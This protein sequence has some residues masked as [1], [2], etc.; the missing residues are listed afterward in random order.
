MKD[1]TTSVIDLVDQAGAIDNQPV[2]D[3]LWAM[4]GRLRDRIEPTLGLVADPSAADLADLRGVDGS[5]VGRIEALTGPLT[6][7]AIHSWIGQP[8]TGFS[9]IHLTV[10]NP[11]TIRTPH[12]GVATGT[13]PLPWLLLDLPM[14]TD[15]AIDLEHFDRYY[16]PANERWLEVKERADLSQFIS[17]S[18]YVR[19]VVSQ[20]GLIFRCDATDEHLQ[21]I[22]ELAVEF[23]DRWLGWMA[24]PEPTPEA[25]Q[26]ALAA[27]DLQLRKNIAER[28]PANPMGERIFGAELTDRL[29]GNLWGRDRAT[30]RPGGFP[31][32]VS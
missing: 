12:L 7:W 24:D 31:N 4:V 5:P 30:E 9:N 20:V 26:A 13:F 16:E 23:V 17:R 27:R 32:A 15:L 10:W 1:T 3:H 29:I 21:L 18:L 28:D 25:E 6:D 19:Q 8:A 11:A 2:F 14:R 22:E